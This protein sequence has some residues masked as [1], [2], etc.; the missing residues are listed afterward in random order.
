MST[1]TGP[2]T[3]PT[4]SQPCP[5]LRPSQSQLSQ[6]ISGSSFPNSTKP[7]LTY[8]RQPHKKKPNNIRQLFP[9]KTTHLQSAKTQQPF[10][11]HSISPP[12]HSSPA[13]FPTNVRHRT[14]QPLSTLQPHL[15]R[16]VVPSQPSLT[17]TAFQQLVRT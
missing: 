13:T 5:H 16:L 2:P 11:L 9:A 8:D 3:K 6:P 4:P 17:A 7:I 12:S 10:H 15:R 1:T 14:S